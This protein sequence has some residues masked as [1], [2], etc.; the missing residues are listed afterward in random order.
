MIT[1]IIL[2]ISE[3]QKKSANIEK[4]LMVGGQLGVKKLH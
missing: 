2:F 1:N 3:V 4:V